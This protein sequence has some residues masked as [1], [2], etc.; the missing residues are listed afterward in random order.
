MCVCVRLSVCLN[1]PN[2][3]ADSV[4]PLGSKGERKQHID[5]DIIDK[6]GPEIG[7][8]SKPGTMSKSC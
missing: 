4:T 5:T 3:D 6:A 8:D 1:V 7:A 2:T